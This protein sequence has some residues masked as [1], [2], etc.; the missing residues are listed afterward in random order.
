M[1]NNEVNGRGIAVI[2]KKNHIAEMNRENTFGLVSCGGKSSRMGRDKAFIHYYDQPQLLVVYRMLDNL[3]EKTFVSC[4]RNQTPQINKECNILTD[5]ERYANL[6]PAASLLTAI[7]NFPEKNF[8]IVGCDYPLLNKQELEKFIIDID[9]KTFAAAF[10]NPD[11]DKYEPLI[12]YYSS[13]AARLFLDGFPDTSISLQHFLRDHGAIKYI[14]SNVDVIK[15]ID[16]PEDA[17]QVTRRISNASIQKVNTTKVISG[18]QFYQEDSLVLEEPLEVRMQFKE[19]GVDLQKTISITMRTPG[20]D[21]ALAAGFLFTEGILKDRSQ[22][23]MIIPSADGNNTVLVIVNDD[24]QPDMLSIQRNFYATSSCGICGKASI[25]SIRAVSVFHDLNNNFAVERSIIYSLPEKL[26][27]VQVLFESTGGLHASALFTAAGDLIDLAEDVG[28]HNALDKLIGYFFNE[29][30]LPL[31]DYM[32]FLSGRTSF[33]LVQ[34]AYMAGIKMIVAVGA[35]S[36]LAVALAESSD[37]TLIG[38][39]RGNKFNVYTGI[40]RIR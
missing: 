10:F 22:I 38:F 1:E 23:K 3:C 2:Y 13:A 6:G 27:K 14:P 40:K 36:S 7:N 32:L 16:T 20:N 35:P 21:T 29:G 31:N 8:L 9:D 5:D 25:E 26:K 18:E 15:S 37:I 34:K 11:A 30:K 33:E 28:R 12:A 19:G 24:V 39:L 17:L 4:S